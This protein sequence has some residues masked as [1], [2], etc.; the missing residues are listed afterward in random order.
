VQLLPWLFVMFQT[1]L[2]FIFYLI[3]FFMVLRIKPWASHMLYHWAA[4]PTPDL[5]VFLFLFLVELEFELRTSFLQSILY[6]LNH[7]F[8]LFC[9]GLF[10]D[11]VL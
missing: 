7:T 8:S 3:D 9:S 10:G 11:G 6:H 2:L 1:H 4:L 5:S